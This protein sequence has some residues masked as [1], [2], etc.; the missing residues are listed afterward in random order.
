M[1][2]ASR[3]VEGLVVLGLMAAAVY[4]A[5]TQRLHAINV[6]GRVIHE[7]DPWFNFR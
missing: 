3:A 1:S 6:Y 4:M 7:F 5:Y 2:F